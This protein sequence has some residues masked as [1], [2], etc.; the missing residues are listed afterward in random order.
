MKGN[1]R[2]GTDAPINRGLRTQGKR[3][4]DDERTIR[5]TKPTASP[6]GKENPCNRGIWFYLA[7]N[8]RRGSLVLGLAGVLCVKCGNKPFMVL[9]SIDVKVEEKPNKKDAI[10]RH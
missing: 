2:R 3:G 10:K 4:E 1:W 5:N 6:A 9:D 7:G 8:A